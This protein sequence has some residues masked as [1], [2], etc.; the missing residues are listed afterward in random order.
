M[1]PFRIAAFLCPRSI[2]LKASIFLCILHSLAQLYLYHYYGSVL[3][4]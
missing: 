4:D 2:H 3:P 1:I